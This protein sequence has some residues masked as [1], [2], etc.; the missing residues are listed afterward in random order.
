MKS[1]AL[2]SGVLLTLVTLATLTHGDYVEMTQDY[3]DEITGF[4]K[5]EMYDKVKEAHKTILEQKISWLIEKDNAKVWRS[6]IDNLT[7][8][9]LQHVQALE[10]AKDDILSH[11]KHQCVSLLQVQKLKCLDC[12]SSQCNAFAKDT[13]D[14]KT[15]E[16][17]ILEK[18]IQYLM[19]LFHI[20]SDFAQNADKMSQ[21]AVEQSAKNLRE[22]TEKLIYQLEMAK[23][24]IDDAGSKL[25]VETLKDNMEEVAETGKAYVRDISSKIE[26]SEIVL[27]QLLVKDRQIQET[28]AQ[29]LQE[30]KSAAQISPKI[31]KKSSSIFGKVWD[32]TKEVFSET[33][34][35][36]T[37]GYWCPNKKTSKSDKKESEVKTEAPPKFDASVL[38]SLPTCAKL[39]A[40]ISLCLNFVKSCESD[41]V[42]MDINDI[43]PRWYSEWKGYKRAWMS[44]K[45]S[46]QHVYSELQSAEEQMMAAIGKHN[47]AV[48]HVLTN[49][50]WLAAYANSSEPLELI[51]ILDV[52]FDPASF[53]KKDVH[54]FKNSS[55]NVQL[56]D[57]EKLQIKL[58]ELIDP[59]DAKSVAEAAMAQIEDIEKKKHFDKHDIGKLIEMFT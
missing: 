21:A 14:F 46:L 9:V 37:F 35:L 45:T 51:K 52:K 23:K 43:C 38:G 44:T 20:E 2:L 53:D 15:D 33:M 59:Y 34:C 57:G 19:E 8:K 32:G 31:V 30:A 40:N 39:Q 36:L 50:G 7:A 47:K 54:M 18:I 55:I 22:T 12:V 25:D 28:L 17:S 6:E 3:L 41:C 13:C 16:N 1:S 29:E 4:V 11:S 24:A 58:K 5:R 27:D 49:F 48:A 26:N 10:G 56:A 42:N